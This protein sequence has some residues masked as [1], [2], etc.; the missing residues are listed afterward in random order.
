[1]DLHSNIGK[2][3]R[4]AKLFFI[5]LLVIFYI[6][7]YQISPTPEELSTQWSKLEYKPI[8]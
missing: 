3:L 7:L 1:M 2:I 8:V 6:P 5:L 4:E